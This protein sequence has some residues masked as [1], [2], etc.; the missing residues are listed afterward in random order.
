[1]EDEPI[2]QNHH[3]L[4]KSKQF[5]SLNPTKHIQF[6]FLKPKTKKMICFFEL[7]LKQIEPIC[8]SQLETIT[9]ETNLL[10]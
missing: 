4:N 1:M 5:D 2:N 6:I 3:K 10:F 9:N 8:F 7:E